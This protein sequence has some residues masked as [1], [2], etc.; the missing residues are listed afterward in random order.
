M[1]GQIEDLWDRQFCVGWHSSGAGPSGGD[2][3]AE[4]STAVGGEEHAR[5]KDSEDEGTEEGGQGRGCG[6]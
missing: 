5:Q 1:L 6:H 3:S 2:V 4:E